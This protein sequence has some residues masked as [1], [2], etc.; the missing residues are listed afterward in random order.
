MKQKTVYFRKNFEKGNIIINSDNKIS[1]KRGDRKFIT[2][3]L[4]LEAYRKT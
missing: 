3:F 4:F 2:F 1:K